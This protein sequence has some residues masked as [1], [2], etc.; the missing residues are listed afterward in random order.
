MIMH[1][2]GFYLDEHG[3]DGDFVCFMACFTDLPHDNIN[4]ELS[5]TT[6]IYSH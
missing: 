5:P 3:K 6:M 4:A 2:I 1:T